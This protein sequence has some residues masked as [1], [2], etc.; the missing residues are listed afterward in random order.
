VEA[1]A[2]GMV[3]TH[4]LALTEIGAAIGAVVKNVHLKIRWSRER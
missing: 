3:T 1:G 2:I 4:D